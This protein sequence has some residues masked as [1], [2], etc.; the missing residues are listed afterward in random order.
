MGKLKRDFLD[1]CLNGNICTNELVVLPV[2]GDVGFDEYFNYKTSEVI[3][4]KRIFSP[5]E[6]NK[7]LLSYPPIDSKEPNI[8][9]KFFESPSI[10]AKN[11]EFEGCFGIDIT[12]YIGKTDDDH[13]QRLL[14]YISTN[15]SAV[16]M[17]ILFSNNKN[18]IA[19]IYDIL[20]QY[21]EYRLVNL[22]LPEINDLVEYTVSEIRDFTTHVKKPIYTSL[23][24]YY[25]NK[26]YGYETADRLVRLLKA[27]DFTGK[28]EDLR[29]IIEKMDSNSRISGS[30]LGFG[31]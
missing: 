9:D 25:E 18:E 21:A 28:V 11:H 19:S 15:T 8:F 30:S 24:Q 5:E 3:K 6:Q 2:L 14:T 13:F 16:Y 29:K 22:G 17:L 23:K 26:E 4:A 1:K 31:Y 7:L 27:N 12:D 20:N 10:V